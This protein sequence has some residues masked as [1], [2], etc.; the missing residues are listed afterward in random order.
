MPQRSIKLWQAVVPVLV[1]LLIWLYPVPEGLKPEAWHM[2][3]IF[4]ATIV[5]ILCA[6]HYVHFFGGL[7]FYKYADL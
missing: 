1:C 7:Y 5:G 3:A 4:V 2:F 6:P